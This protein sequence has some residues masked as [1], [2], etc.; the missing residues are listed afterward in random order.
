MSIKTFI[1]SRYS[2]DV[3]LYVKTHPKCP[4]SAVRES[5]RGCDQHTLD[6]RLAEMIAEGL[7]AVDDTPRMNRTHQV[8]L[9]P[10]GSEVAVL[11]EA[12]LKLEVTE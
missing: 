9:T 3:L 6:R 4:K 12:I 2:V 10:L 5:A 8:S 11:V 1:C 7:A